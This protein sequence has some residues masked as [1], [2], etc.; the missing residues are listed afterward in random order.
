MR[1]KNIFRIFL[2][3][4][5]TI[6]LFS[7]CNQEETEP[8]LVLTTTAVTDI[9][10]TGAKSGGTIK[11]SDKYVKILLAGVC[12]ATYPNPSTFRNYTD[13][14]F[15]I[16]I[17]KKDTAIV[18]DSTGVKYKSSFNNLKPGTTYYL[19][20]YA[21]TGSGTTTYGNEI[22]FGTTMTDIDK[23]I[24][25][26]VTIGTQTWMVENLRT[27]RYNDSIPI[28]LVEP[29]ATWKNPLPA[30]AP[31]YCW[32]NDVIGNKKTYGALYNWD[33]VNTGKLA[34]KG[35]HVPTNTDWTTL[36]KYVGAHSGRSGTLAK[37]LSDSII[38]SA[39]TLDG[40]IGFDIKTN[41][42]TGFSALPGGYRDYSDG[43][44]YKAGT[45][46]S[47]WSA[48]NKAKGISNDSICGR[49]FNSESKIFDD[50]T[51][52][53]KKNGFYVRCVKD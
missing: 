51:F 37:A 7:A 36:E 50:I 42:S 48:T 22:V 24:Y 4:F 43:K 33:A 31:A 13:I 18:N 45:A 26:V 19:R 47:F 1:I 46:I 20:A 53:N 34:P 41:N 5:F 16:D 2:S 25:H 15:D 23:N 3:V 21:E 8:Y 35:W 14:T 39:S 52:F 6:T 28:P 32:Y 11:C 17:N 29:N 9:T 49:R 30:I 27:T 38:W 40:T 12:W 10:Q 44:F